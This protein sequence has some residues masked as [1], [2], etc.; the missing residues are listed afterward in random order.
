MAT[1][2]PRIKEPEIPKCK[3]CGKVMKQRLDGYDIKTFACWGCNYY[4]KMRLSGLEWI[5][6]EG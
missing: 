2:G 1:D 5:S 4:I 6:K 3:V